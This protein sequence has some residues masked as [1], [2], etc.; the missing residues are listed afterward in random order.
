M[1]L[2]T[3]PGHVAAISVGGIVAF[4]TLQRALF[5]PLGQLLNVQVEIQGTLAL[6]DRIFEYLDLPI[7]I[8][9]KPA[10]VVLDPARVEG[11][12]TFDHVSFQYDAA[13]ERLALEDVSFDALPGQ[14]VALVGPSG[15]GKTTMSYLVTRLYDVTN[16][17]VRIDGLD[18]RDIQLE[19]L[20][21]SI[22]MVTQETYLFH[23]DP[24]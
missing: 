6:F 13:A 10:A 11:R 5:F 16:G 14:L 24:R 3:A 8:K 21:E 18:V 22:G 23:L 7:E 1:I 17:A 20:A 4:T 9:S 12:I 2:G 15:A 19:S